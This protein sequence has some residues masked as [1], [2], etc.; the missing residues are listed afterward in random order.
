MKGGRPLVLSTRP[1]G[2]HDP[3][4]GALREAGLR[5]L[6]VP[7]VAVEPLAFDPPDLGAY[8]WAVVTSAAGVRRL[9][10]RVPPPPPSLRWAAVG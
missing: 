2:E 5:V 1:E 10:E 4:V 6:A 7:T 8:D 9:L 3:L